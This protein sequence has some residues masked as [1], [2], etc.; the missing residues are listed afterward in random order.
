[1]TITQIGHLSLNVPHHIMVSTGPSWPTFNLWN[2]IPGRSPAVRILL[3]ERERLNHVPDLI[4]VG[5]LEDVTP[6]LQ[7]KGLL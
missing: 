2:C 5:R 7:E 6:V 1:M 3:L 4:H